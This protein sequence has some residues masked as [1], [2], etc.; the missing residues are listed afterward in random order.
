VPYQ[1]DIRPSQEFNYELAKTKLGALEMPLQNDN[2]IQFLVPYDGVASSD[3]LDP[4]NMG[5]TA[6]R[7]KI[8]RL[9]GCID[10]ENRV[11]IGCAGALL[12]YLQRKRAREY[13]AGDETVS[14]F[15]VLSVEMFSLQGTM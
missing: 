13:L 3:Q 5:F 2:P 15:R 11:S 6:Q 14:A 12:T 8:L 9:S 7:G 10:M 1:L 4:E